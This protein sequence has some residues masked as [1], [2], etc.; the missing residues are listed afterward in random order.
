M[1]NE[2]CLEFFDV[3]LKLFEVFVCY[4]CCV[5]MYLLVFNFGKR[6]NF[7]MNF[8]CMECFERLRKKK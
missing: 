4:N 1:D 2:L 5:L 7:I 6:Y 3:M 8:Y